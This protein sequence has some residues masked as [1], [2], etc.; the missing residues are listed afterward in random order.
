[1]ARPREF[2]TEKVL[3]I[4]LQT[5]WEMGF[6]GASYA[7]LEKATGVKKASLVAAYGDKQALFNQAIR[8]YLADGRK[9]VTDALC[10]PT[11]AEKAISDWLN[12][13]G[14][15]CIGRN[16]SRGCM[17]LNSLVEQT[18][19]DSEA[20]GLLK[21]N[22]KEI[23]GLLSETIK[24]GV[25]LGEFRSDIQPLAAA[26][27]LTTCTAGL[28]ISGKDQIT[29]EEFESTRKLIMVALK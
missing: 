19:V 14:R 17:A 29:S 27:Y 7:E 3:E 18:G 15:M 26:K 11:S 8:K 20:V 2:D 24:K 16:G 5:F 1:M 25:S 9:V 21:Q 6:K 28:M 4:V 22:K 12:L 10:G 23:L 13:V